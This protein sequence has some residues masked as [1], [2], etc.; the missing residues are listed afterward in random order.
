MN[1]SGYH[2]EYITIYS[3]GIIVLGKYTSGICKVSNTLSPLKGFG[4][5][6]SYLGGNVVTDKI[7]GE[8]TYAFENHTCIKHISENIEN[9]FETTINNFGSPLEG[10][11]HT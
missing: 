2:Y 8:A 10:S 5:Q 6:Y 11:Y 7:H 1:Y 3:N 9:I 4:E